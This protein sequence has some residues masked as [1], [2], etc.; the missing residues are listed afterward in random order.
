MD[1]VYARGEASAT[2]VL[3]D[4]ADP[5]S[6]ASV[7]TLLRIL[8]ERGLLKH[9][10]KAREFIYVPT[11]RRERVGRSAMRRV[12]KTFYDG[13]LEQAVAAHLADDGQELSPEEL[14]RLA[15]LIRK[16]RATRRKG[17]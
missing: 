3:A 12:L 4:M 10:K 14:N 11:R 6:R 16:A 2:H 15:G 7:R 5:P 13:S 1:I 8:E 9:H 17:K